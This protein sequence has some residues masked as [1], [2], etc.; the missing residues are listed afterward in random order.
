MIIRLSL[1][2]AALAIS[3]VA[4]AQSPT[5][6]PPLPVTGARDSLTAPSVDDANREIRR[7]P[8]GVDLVPSE[9][10]RD[11]SAQGVK[12][13]LD[14]SPGVFAQPKYG[15][16]DSR[17]SIRGSGLSRNF[18]LRGIRILLDGVPINLADGGGDFHEIDPLATRYV[19]VFRGANAL[20][21]GAASLGGAVNFVSP[22]GRDSPGVL[23]RLSGG[24]FGTLTTQLAYGGVSG[25]F[26]FWGSGTMV[27]SDGYRDH[28]NEIYGRFTGNVGYRF[29]ASSE[30]RMY[31]GLNYDIN[32]ITGSLTRSQAYTTPRAVPAASTNT[33]NTHRDVRSVRVANRSTFLIGDDQV[34]VSA[35]LKYKDLFHPLSFGVVDNKSLDWGGTAQYRGERQIAGLKNE[36]TAGLN[37]FVGENRNRTYVNNGGNRGAL[38]ND[39]MEH[40]LNIDLYGENRLWL[41]PGFALVLGTQLNFSHRRLDDFFPSNGNDSGTRDYWS[42]NP[43]IGALWEPAKNIQIFANVSRAAEPPPFSELNPSAAP[44]FAN[45][46]QQKSWTAE[47]GARGKLFDRVGFDLSLY[48]AWVKDEIQLLIL[49]G[50]P[51]SGVA[52]NVDRTIHQGVELG[53]DATLLKGLATGQAADGDSL[54]LRLAYTYSNFYFDR[55]RTYGSNIIP[56]APAHY[57]RAELRYTHPSG[58]YVAPNIEWVPMGY[59]VD[60][61]NTAS[62]MTDPYVLFG[63]K[64]GAEPVKGM[65]LFLDVRNIFNKTYVSNVSVTTSATAASAL[66]NPGIGRAIFVG[67]ELRL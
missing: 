63:L 60:N 6:L 49:P 2:A 56:G 50:F 42:V 19:E 8:G 54:A 39:N 29:D 51:P 36:F 62:L 24:S 58:F 45:L 66:Y 12:D 5:T 67:A 41:L 48:R 31:V 37:V 15:Q 65:R 27:R 22:T 53:L 9:R 32:E 47:V 43:R 11:T 13:V 17:L 10:F 14:F 16:E 21:W 61:A 35:Y 4:M 44:G 59:Y 40:A 7:I 57:L 30:T 26:D 52:S 25:G 38:T 1:G 34:T 20:Q 64:A 33:L 23:A 3:S 46:P 28:T 55:D 18:H